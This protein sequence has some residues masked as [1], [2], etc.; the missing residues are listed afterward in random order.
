MVVGGRG[1]VFCIMGGGIADKVADKVTLRNLNKGR[2]CC[3]RGWLSKQT[4]HQVPAPPGESVLHGPRE[5]QDGRGA[6]RE[7]SGS[8]SFRRCVQEQ[9]RLARTGLGTGLR[10]SGKAWPC[11]HAFRWRT[12]IRETF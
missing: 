11:F 3:P 2:S 10:W 6:G 1:A 5:R 7:E 8:I 4:K 12:F 9:I